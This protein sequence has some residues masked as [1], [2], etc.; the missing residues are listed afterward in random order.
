M[1]TT[2][3]HMRTLAVA[4]L[5]LGGDMNI[6]APP[7]LAPGIF[8]SLISTGVNDWGGVSPVTQDFINPEAPWPHLD[9]L[10]ERTISYGYV[11]RERLAV[12]PTYV[13]SRQVYLHRA[14]W[15]KVERV[16][17]PDGYAKVDPNER[18]IGHTQGWKSKGR[19]EP[20]QIA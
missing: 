6:Q 12:Y 3:D 18:P 17:G 13:T 14:L 15:P 7:N 8:E 5:V 4:R 10:H 2:E 20:D 9:E 16:C 1:P 11:L 19:G